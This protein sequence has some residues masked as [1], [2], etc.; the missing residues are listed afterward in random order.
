MET[1]LAG[2]WAVRGRVSSVSRASGKISFIAVEDSGLAVYVKI[3]NDNAFEA[4]HDDF[5]NLLMNRVW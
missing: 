5:L 4:G 3:K 1:A 2:S